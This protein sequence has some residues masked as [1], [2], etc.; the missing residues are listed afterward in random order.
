MFSAFKTSFKLKNAYRVNTIIYSIKQFP[1]LNK[2]VS[3]SLYKNDALKIL[4]SVLSI[5][6]E[7]FTTFFGK[8]V[9]T[10][11]FVFGISLLYQT[12]L[13]N[14]FLQLKSYFNN[15]LFLVFSACVSTCGQIVV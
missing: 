5:L 12:N 6:Y 14:N 9:Y 8:V 7:I 15:F 4:A 10:L 13:A 3:S 11:I 2:I 1:G